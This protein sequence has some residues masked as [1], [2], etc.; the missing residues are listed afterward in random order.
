MKV[1]RILIADD[2]E[3]V[4]RGVRALMEA[5]PGC[6]VCGEAATGRQAVERARES[7]PD[8]VIMDLS[9]PEL[10]GLEPTRQILKALPKTEVL[11]LTVHESTHLGQEVLAA[12]ARGYILKSDDGRDLVTAVEQLRRHRPFFTATVTRMVLHNYLDHRT[13]SCKDESG[14]LSL[15][16]REREIA[17]L[18]A[19]GKSNKEVATI[20]D[21][22]HKTVEAHRTNLMRKLNLHSLTELVHYAIRNHIVE[23]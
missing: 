10:N 22:S 23:P 3:L 18:L 1:C 21:I 20:L 9:L 7:R 19:E 12:G 4:R 6:E 16:T 17:Q 14:G 13:P 11:V 8:L 2:H 15:T 5:Q